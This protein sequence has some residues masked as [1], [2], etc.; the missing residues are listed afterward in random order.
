MNLQAVETL[1]GIIKL[2]NYHTFS[3]FECRKYTLPKANMAGEDPPDDHIF[4]DDHKC[5]PSQLSLG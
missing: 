2:Q 1:A 5:V 4:L 3:L